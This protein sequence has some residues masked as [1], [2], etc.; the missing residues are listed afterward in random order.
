[1]FTGSEKFRADI[2]AWLT[3]IVGT[4]LRTS[5]FYDQLFV[6]SHLLRSPSP[7]VQWASHFLQLSLP[8]QFANRNCQDPFVKHFTVMLRCLLTPTKARDDFLSSF[9]INQPSSGED[10]DSSWIVVDPD[11]EG[12]DTMR[13]TTTM[14]VKEGDVFCLLRQFRFDQLYACLFGSDCLDLEPFTVISDYDVLS[15][16]GF[17][18]D[19]LEI[20]VEGLSNTMLNKYPRYNKRLAQIIRDLA[21]HSKEFWER[22]KEAKEDDNTIVKNLQVWFLDKSIGKVRKRSLFSTD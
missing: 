16:F 8:T 5:T 14:E 2:R 11:A 15:L 7:V 9:A 22:L 18:Y 17:C 20:L 12:H 21:I 6:L 19:F 1:M 4:L 10:P 13:A 3:E